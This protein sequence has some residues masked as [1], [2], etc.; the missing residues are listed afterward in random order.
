MIDKDRKNVVYIAGPISGTSDYMER[1]KRAED[2]LREYD[3]IPVNPTIV[4]EP[5]VAANCEYE[6]FMNVTHQLLRICGAICLLNGW[7]QS[8]G[9]LR[10]LKYALDNEY[11]VFSEASI[12]F[13]EP[14]ICPSCC[15][16]FCCYNLDK[17]A[18]MNNAFCPN[19]GKSLIFERRS[20]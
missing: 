2:K 10:E 19:C 1:F 15:T 13:S 12:F 8:N 16:S 6:E 17:N 9:A 5:M 4:S 7:E 11:D 20:Q 3:Y 14:N 18:P